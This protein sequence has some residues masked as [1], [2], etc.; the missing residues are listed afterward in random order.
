[1]RRYDFR[2][3]DIVRERTAD[4]HPV[5]GKVIGCSSSTEHD[6]YKIASKGEVYSARDDELELVRRAPRRGK[7]DPGIMEEFLLR[8]YAPE[9]HP[10]LGEECLVVWKDDGGARRIDTA[11]WVGGWRMEIEPGQYIQLA[12][13]MFDAWARWEWPE[14]AEPETAEPETDRPETGGWPQANSRSS[15]AARSFTG[16]EGADDPDD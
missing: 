1:M 8:W 4:R 11:L 12:P 6:F 14:T 2:V 10:G 7:G 13:D 16:E 5:I 9:V 3:G 15:R